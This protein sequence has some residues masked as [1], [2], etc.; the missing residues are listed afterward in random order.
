LHAAQVLGLAP[1]ECV[2]VG[3]AE[4]DAQAAQ[5]AG[6][7]SVVAGFGYLG[8]EDRADQWYQHG[9]LDTPLDLLAWL[10]APRAVLA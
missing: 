5:A 10:D 9:W 7:F 6:M 4:R 2:Y 1:A 8:E 3:D